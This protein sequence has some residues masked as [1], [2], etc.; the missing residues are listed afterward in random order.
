M[1]HSLGQ[2][3]VNAYNLLDHSLRVQYNFKTSITFSDLIRRCSSLNQVIRVYEEDLI[4]LARLRNAIVHNRSERII[5]EP[6]EDVVELIEKIARLVSTPPLAIDVISS[7]NVDTIQ[8]TLTLRDLIVETKRVGHS[9]IPVYKNGGLIGII[10]WNTFIQVLGGILEQGNDINGFVV[11]TTVEE[12]LRLYPI[13]VHF[14]IVSAKITIEEIL[15][16]FNTNRKLS[17]ILLTQDGTA[18]GKLLGIITSTDVIDFM[19]VLEGY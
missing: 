8:G 16:L 2:R 6:H 4:E 19:K 11:K 7:G 14:T 15:R 1:T 3:F 18:S 10:R 17:S 12:F 9:N 13:N 5:A